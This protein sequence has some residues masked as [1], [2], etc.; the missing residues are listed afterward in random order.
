[1]MIMGPGEAVSFA[2]TIFFSGAVP[3]HGVQACLS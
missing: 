2:P 1:M 3:D